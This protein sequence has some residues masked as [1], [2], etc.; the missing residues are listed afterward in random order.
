VDARF[1]NTA[2]DQLNGANTFYIEIYYR[3]KTNNKLI[4]SLS[5]GRLTDIVDIGANP[6]DGDP[7]RTRKCL[8]MVYVMLSV[9]SLNQTP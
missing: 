4:N 1:C 7:P 5:P 9:L 2:N 6:I 3:Q 8:I